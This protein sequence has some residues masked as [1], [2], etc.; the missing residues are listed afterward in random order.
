MKIEVSKAQSSWFVFKEDNPDMSRI[1]WVR[2][3][4]RTVMLWEFFLL[5]III[6]SNIKNRERI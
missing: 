4:L 3:R 6:Q 1:K 2:Q 5:L